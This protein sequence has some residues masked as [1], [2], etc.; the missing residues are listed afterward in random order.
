MSNIMQLCIDS[1]FPCPG[2]PV[3]VV[4]VGGLVVAAVAAG[5]LGLLGDEDLGYHGPGQETEPDTREHVGHHR[6]RRGSHDWE[7]LIQWRTQIL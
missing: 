6:G 5:L 2:S 3:P 1:E 7:N 4:I